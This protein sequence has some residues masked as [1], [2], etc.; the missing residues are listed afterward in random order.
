VP[1]YDGQFRVVQREVVLEDVRRQVGAGAEHVTFGDPD[2]FNGPGHVLPIVER[3]HDE[4]PE[5]TYDVTIKIE[6]LLRHRK[7][8]PRLRDTGCLFVTSAVEAW[9]D[10]V[11]EQLDKGH[12]RAD[13]VEVVRLMRAVGLNL[14]PTFVPFTPWT[15]LESY[16]ELLAAVLDLDL[17]DHVA[18]IQ[19]GIR[20]LVSGNSRLLELNDVRRVAGPLDPRL[21]VHPWRHPDRRVDE[22]CDAVLTEVLAAQRRGDSRRRAFRG[23][24]DLAQAALGHRFAGAARVAELDQAAPRASVPYLTEPWYC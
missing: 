23:L 11:L 9:D 6:H 22:L 17:V 8:L 3:L 15:T 13:F 16:G 14:A 19:Y 20:L 24:W 21:L 7:L 10:A 18:P 4:F 2:F 1:V 5:L 12:T